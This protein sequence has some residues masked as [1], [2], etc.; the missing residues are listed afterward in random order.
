MYYIYYTFNT[1]TAA[2]GTSDKDFFI[3]SNISRSG[4]HT[5]LES[6]QK[7]GECHTIL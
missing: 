5:T 2:D 6:L 7:K 4:N 1:E 3:Q